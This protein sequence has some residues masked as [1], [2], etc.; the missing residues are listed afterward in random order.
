MV[1]AGLGEPST[2][3][4]LENL[5]AN[6]ILLLSMGPLPKV[7]FDGLYTHTAENVW[8]QIREGAST[9]NDLILSANHISA[10]AWTSRQKTGNQDFHWWMTHTCCKL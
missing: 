7:V 3:A 6:Q 9:L 5:H 10:A 1:V 4:L 2:S 8:P